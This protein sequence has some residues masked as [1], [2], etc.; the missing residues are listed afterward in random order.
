MLD[1]VAGLL[2]QMTLRVYKSAVLWKNTAPLGMSI[3]EDRKGLI[4]WG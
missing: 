3:W 2:Q 4:F 1:A